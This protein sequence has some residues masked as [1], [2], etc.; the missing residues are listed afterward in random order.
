MI[1]NVLT[2]VAREVKLGM[3][4]GNK[5][6]YTS[7]IQHTVSGSTTSTACIGVNIGGRIR[8]IYRK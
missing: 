6:T 2:V 3:A 4:I 5:Y 1:T 7:R 8:Q